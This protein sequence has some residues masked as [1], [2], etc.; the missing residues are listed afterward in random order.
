MSFNLPS[1]T[2]APD[3]RT[4]QALRLLD[5]LLAGSNSARLKKHLQFNEE[6]FSQISSGY[7]PFN[8]GDSL[9]L[10]SA[11]LNTHQQITLDQAQARIWQVIEHLKTT[12]WTRKNWSARA[13]C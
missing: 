1:L 5:I 3:R 9:L 12:P 8:R 6:L 2:T 13:P 7:N 10:L 4:V 11:Q